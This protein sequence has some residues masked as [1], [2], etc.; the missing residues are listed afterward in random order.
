MVKKVYRGNPGGRDGWR[1][2]KE[3]GNQEAANFSP[4]PSDVEASC[5]TGPDSTRAVVPRMFGWM[6]VCCIEKQDN[7][8]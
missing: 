4:G 7:T 6:G 8:K 2:R 1:V 3:N 5:G